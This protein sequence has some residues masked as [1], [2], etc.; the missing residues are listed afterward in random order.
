[1]DL[2]GIQPQHTKFTH[3][4]THTHTTDRIRQTDE[5]VGGKLEWQSGSDYVENGP[6]AGELA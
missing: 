5:E 3:I 4:Q 6:A 1:M 2:L